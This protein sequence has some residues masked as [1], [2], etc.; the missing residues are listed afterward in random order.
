MFLGKYCIGVFTVI[1]EFVA[2]SDDV[3]EIRD[4]ETREIRGLQQQCYF[5]LPN[6]AFPVQGK[7]RV[8]SRMPPGKYSF[9]PS[10][11]IGRFGDLEVNPFETPKLTTA[12]PEQVKAAG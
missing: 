8:E 6:S 1:V 11:R 7:I 4:K 5:H 2:G 12:R 10:Y 9:V 3:K